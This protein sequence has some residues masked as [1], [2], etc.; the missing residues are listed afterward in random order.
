MNRL[1]ALLVGV[2]LTLLLD[3]GQSKGKDVFVAGIGTNNCSVLNALNLENMQ[4][5]D[6]LIK[7]MVISWMQGYLIGQNVVTGIRDYIQL[8]SL[9]ADTKFEILASK[10]KEAPEKPLYITINEL[11][12]YLGKGHYQVHWFS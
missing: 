7:E 5:G 3:A 9:S 8:G 11:I 2:I 1:R 6:H 10:C 12:P 4:P